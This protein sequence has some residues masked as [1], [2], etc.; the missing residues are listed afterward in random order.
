V[1]TFGEI[2]AMRNE[3]AKLRCG[4]SRVVIVDRVVRE[5]LCKVIFELRPKLEQEP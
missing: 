2:P 3:S 1:S 5:D 4:R